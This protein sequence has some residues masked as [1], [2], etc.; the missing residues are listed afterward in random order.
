MDMTLDEIKD[1]LNEFDRFSKCNGMRLVVLR[2]GYAEAEMEL[3]CNALNG[4]DIA[5]GGAVFTLAD[6][7]L[8]GA[9]NSHGVHA[10]AMNSNIAYVR[11][12]L[13]KTLRAIAREVNRGKRTGLYDIEVFNDQNKL[14]AKMTSTA[15]YHETRFTR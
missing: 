13:G 8:A 7:A 14:V 15:F 2:E 9:A 1:V 11:P 5:Q 6:L 4:L 3:T 12:G 10:V